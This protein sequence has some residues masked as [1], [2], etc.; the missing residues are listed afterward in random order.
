MP[1]RSTIRKIAIA[2]LSTSAFGAIVVGGTLLWAQITASAA[3]DPAFV[4]SPVP[5]VILGYGVV[6]LVGAVGLWLHWPWVV[7][8]VIVS[9][10]LA[11]V[12]LLG[13]SAFVVADW[14]LLIVGAIAA[15]AALCVGWLAVTARRA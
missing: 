7:P 15:G 13:F 12:Y 6:S 3:A 8:V 10:A 14:S 2:L 9:Q 5:S 1:R 4:S 11:A